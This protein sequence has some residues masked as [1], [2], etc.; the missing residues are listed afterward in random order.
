MLMIRLSRTGRKNAPTYRLIVSE[1]GRDPWGKSL[2]IVGHY[3]PR[4][5]EREIVIDAERVKYWISKGAQASETVWNL[6]VDQKIVEGKK[7]GASHISKK[8][9]GEMNKAKIEAEKA[10]ADKKAAEEAAKEAAKAKA[11]EEKAAAEAAAAAEKEAAEAAAAAPAP[12]EETPAA[13]APAAEET[14]AA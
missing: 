6:L 4:R 5:E 12:A 13:E 7:R 10:A 3:N 9:F 8:R 2:E 11:A 1:K 14:P